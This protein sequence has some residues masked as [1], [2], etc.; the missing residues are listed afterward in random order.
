M[1]FTTATSF[2]TAETF[3]LKAAATIAYRTPQAIA[4]IQ[5]GFEVS[6]LVTNELINRSRPY[7]RAA[8]AIA[9]VIGASLACFVY[10]QVAHQWQVRVV[11][12]QLIPVAQG[13]VLGTVD[14][15]RDRSSE[16]RP[17]I[18]DYANQV[19]TA[20]ATEYAAAINHA[21]ESAFCLR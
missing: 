13:Y 21:L 10:Q 16:V 2:T 4:I 11:E 3:A 6:R 15:L 20:I 9:W 19:R 12:P 17:A 5:T 14:L 18:C 1:T 7:I 8:V